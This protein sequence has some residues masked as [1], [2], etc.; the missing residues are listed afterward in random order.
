MANIMNEEETAL[1]IKLKARKLETL[2]EYHLAQLN[3][4]GTTYKK[5]GCKSFF[6]VWDE[7]VRHL[8]IGHL[9]YRDRYK[10]IYKEDYKKR[11]KDRF[12]MG[13]DID[14][15]N[16]DS[17]PLDVLDALILDLNESDS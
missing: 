17:T 5:Y 11:F 7:M 16:K 2:E 13:I 8:K 14:K 15:L 9:N 4:P 3:F 10:N 6:Y 12:G 1:W